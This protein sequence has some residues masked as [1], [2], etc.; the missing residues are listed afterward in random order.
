[1]YRAGSTGRVHIHIRLGALQPLGVE[2][3]QLALRGPGGSEIPIRLRRD[4][5]ADDPSK[6]LEQAFVG[7]FQTGA[8]Q[9]HRVLRATVAVAG[10]PP[11]IVERS[12]GVIA[13]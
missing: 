2:A 7:E 6:P 13:R 10:A 5:A 4:P 11:R 8:V 3:L 1:M 9:G 12:I